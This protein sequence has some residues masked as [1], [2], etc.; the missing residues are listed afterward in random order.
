MLDY[1]ACLQ[2]R[3][4]M[5][6]PKVKEAKEDVFKQCYEWFTAHL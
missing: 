4:D 2:V 5:S 3:G 6:N 1:R